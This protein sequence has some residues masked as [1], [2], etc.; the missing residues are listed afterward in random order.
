MKKVEVFNYQ[1]ADN[2]GNIIIQNI[3]SKSEIESQL[4][5]NSRLLEEDIEEAIRTMSNTGE[6]L[7]VDLDNGN[8]AYYKSAKSVVLH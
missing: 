1:E 8:R 7:F 6:V 4:L 2:Q 3:I 5:N